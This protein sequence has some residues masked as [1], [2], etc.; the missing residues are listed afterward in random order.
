MYSDAV[1][2]HKLLCKGYCNNYATHCMKVTVIIILLCHKA[3]IHDL[4]TTAKKS[5]LIAFNKCEM[6][7]VSSPVLKQG[8]FSSRDMAGDSCI[9][10]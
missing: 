1:I 9:K 4:L 2:E 8:E 10:E 6:S 5:R 7:C 3:Y